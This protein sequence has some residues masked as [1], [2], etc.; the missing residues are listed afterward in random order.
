MCNV[1]IGITNPYTFELSEYLGYDIKTLKDNA[2][3]MEIV[4]NRN[5]RANGICP[6]YFDGAIDKY[7]EL[8][9]PNDTVNIEK[10]YNFIR[11]QSKLF[12]MRSITK[13]ESVFVG[14]TFLSK[15]ASYFSKLFN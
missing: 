1:L 7:A 8:P 15:F 11:Q 13:T 2:R 5:G 14:N 4:L 3:F 6:L 10:V 12:F 9:L